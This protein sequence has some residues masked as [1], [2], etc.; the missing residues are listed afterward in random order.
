LRELV[1]QDCRNSYRESARHVFGP[2]IDNVLHCK[3]ETYSAASVFAYS[4]LLARGLPSSSRPS[5]TRRANSLLS[6]LDRRHCD[7]EFE[8][9]AAPKGS[10]VIQAMLKRLAADERSNSTEK[11]AGTVG[12]MTALVKRAAS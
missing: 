5:R 11:V 8:A 6:Q 4:H 2:K 7:K 9:M 3:Q 1:W 12:T 10:T